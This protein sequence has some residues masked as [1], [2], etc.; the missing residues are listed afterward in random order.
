MNYSDNLLGNMKFWKL[1]GIEKTTE[2]IILQ[3]LEYD[4]FTKF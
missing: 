2:I 3:P 1:S 4:I